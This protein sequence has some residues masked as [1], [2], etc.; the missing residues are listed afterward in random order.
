MSDGNRSQPKDDDEDVAAE[1]QRIHSG[2]SRKD[3]LQIRDLCKVRLSETPATARLVAAW[4]INNA[5]V[6]ALF[7][8]LLRHLATSKMKHCVYCTL[9]CLGGVGPVHTGVF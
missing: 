1:R 3:I 6:Q 8:I 7:G 5:L 4:W 2:G 9:H